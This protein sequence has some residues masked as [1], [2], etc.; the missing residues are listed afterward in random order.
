MIVLQN[1]RVYQELLAV[2]ASALVALV[3]FQHR[4]LEA[5]AYPTD[6]V[7]AVLALTA[8]D[9]GASLPMAELARS[10]PSATSAASAA[11]PPAK[12]ERMLVLGDSM[13][14]VLAP[15]LN[16]YGIEKGQEMVPG[17]WYGSRTAGG[18][19]SPELGRLL[20]EIN[21]TMGMVVLGSSELTSRS[22]ESRRP[23][24]EAIL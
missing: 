14:E 6:D 23:F 19:S 9:D 15:E 24:I 11:P 17:I 8:A 20:R 4:P 12:R 18:A 21:P 16:A 10:A 5:R 22:I 1:L 7:D 13:V 2:L 3:L